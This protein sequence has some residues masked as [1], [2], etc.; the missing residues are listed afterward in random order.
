MSRDRSV[1]PR[2]PPQLFFEKSLLADSPLKSHFHNADLERGFYPCVVDRIGGWGVSKV[3]FGE[4]TEGEIYPKALT[5]P[6]DTLGGTSLRASPEG[7]SK[8]RLERLKALYA[9]TLNFAV[10]YIHTK[11]EARLNSF[12]AS[13]ERIS[14]FEAST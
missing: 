14:G 8:E 11:Q 13:W 9:T 12:F 3:F 7:K 2:I 5:F 10:N 6:V 4:R 1:F